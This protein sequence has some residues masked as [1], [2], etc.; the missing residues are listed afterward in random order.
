MNRIT[1]N[2]IEPGKDPLGILQARGTFDGAESGGLQHVVDV[3]PRN[4][5][6]H[7]CAESLAMLSK[8]PSYALHVIHR[9]FVAYLREPGQAQL[10]S[11]SQ[12]GSQEHTSPQQQPFSPGSTHSHA[13]EAGQAWHGQWQ[14]SVFMG[15][16]PF[17][18]RQ[19]L[20]VGL[21]GELTKGRHHTLQWRPI[22]AF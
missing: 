20:C 3:G 15:H 5:S 14:R 7:E 4:A 17:E 2:P 19:T 8:S 13:H 22:L 9:S 21:H 12:F 10:A 11:H 18:D 1:V 16:S 6:P